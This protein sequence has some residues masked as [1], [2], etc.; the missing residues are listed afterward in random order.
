[1]AP[2]RLLQGYVQV[3]T[4]DGKGKTTAA[5]GLVFRAAGHG[6]RS[7]VIQFMKGDI[8]YGEIAAARRLGGLVT[9][10][11]MGRASFVDRDNPDPEDVRLAGEA[12]RLARQ[13]VSSGQF[14][15]VVLDEVNVALDFGLIAVGDVLAL[16][17]AKPSHV[18]LILTGRNA[19]QAILDAADLVTEMR[20][21]KH[22]YD[23]GVA[24]RR[25]I[26]L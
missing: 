12:L 7:H 23:R 24:S 9:I 6:L 3:Y 2:A 21:L 8:R 19:P 26:E 13:S 15:L 4:G 16:I 5:M 11:Q 10:T 25:G 20:C 18:E 1:M 14:D 22:Y 17:A